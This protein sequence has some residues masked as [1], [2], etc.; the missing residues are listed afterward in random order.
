MA[1]IDDLAGTFEQIV[2]AINRRDAGAYSS[3]WHE[4]IVAFPPFSPFAVE[5]KSTLVPLA[6]ANFANAESL[7]LTPINPQCRVIGSTGIVWGHMSLAVKPKDGPLS[8]TFAR[9]TFIFAKTDGKWQE[10]AIHASQL[11]SGS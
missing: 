1:D 9:F 7:S 5:G 8:A 10:V 11:P 2:A 3:F 6:E 4:Q